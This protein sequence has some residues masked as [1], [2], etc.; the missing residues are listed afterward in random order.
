[1]FTILFAVAI[2]I[3]AIIVGILNYKM[4]SRL[5]T[6]SSGIMGECAEQHTETLR[7]I[8]RTTTL[9]VVMGGIVVALVIGLIG[10]GLL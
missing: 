3:V 1:V 5:I 4:Y 2:A 9:I 8:R 7:V 10:Y 6:A